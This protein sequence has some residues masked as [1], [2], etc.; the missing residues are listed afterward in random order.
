MCCCVLYY[1]LLL[2]SFGRCTLTHFRVAFFFRILYDFWCCCSDV[3]FVKIGQLPRAHIF[4]HK[5]KNEEE[6][7]QAHLDFEYQVWLNW[8]ISALALHTF[9]VL[10]YHYFEILF[11]FTICFALFSLSVVLYSF[12]FY[13]KFRQI[14]PVDTFC[15]CTFLVLCSLMSSW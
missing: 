1:W 8:R 15:M 3:H 7:K 4:V 2:L 14:K 13:F 10:H 6:T 11:R 12:C 5:A 9:N